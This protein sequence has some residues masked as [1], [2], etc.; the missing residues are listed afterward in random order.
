MTEEEKRL[1]LEH[2]EKYPP[3]QTIEDGD[4]SNGEEEEVKMAWLTARVIQCE[5]VETNRGQIGL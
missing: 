2:D 1:W 4:Y 3:S 5:N